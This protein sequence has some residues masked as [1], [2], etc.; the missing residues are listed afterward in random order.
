MEGLLRRTFR[1]ITKDL[2]R[3]SE[4]EIEIHKCFLTRLFDL[5]EILDMRIHWIAELHSESILFII[6]ISD[7]L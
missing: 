5:L 7:S 2:V 3:R 1:P 4:G 6:Y